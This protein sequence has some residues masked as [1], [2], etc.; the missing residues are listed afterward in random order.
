[1]EEHTSRTFGLGSGHTAEIVNQVKTYLET[2]PANYYDQMDSL[3]E[4]IYHASTGFNSVE[5]PEFKAA[6]NPAG[7]TA[8]VIGGNR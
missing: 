3:L 4:L 1:M 7:S 5:A 2:H 8:A 6:V